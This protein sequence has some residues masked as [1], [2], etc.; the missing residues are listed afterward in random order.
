MRPKVILSVA[1]VALLI[2][3][4]ALYYRFAPA[5]APRA[6]PAVET[7]DAAG[8]APAAQPAASQRLRTVRPLEDQVPAPEQDSRASPT[9]ANHQDYVVGRVSE[10]SDLATSND[11][12]SLKVILSE[13][14]NQNAAI[15][16]A[17]L[18]ATV[19]FGGR[20]ALPALSNQMTWTEDPREKMAIQNAI[21]F[22]QL[23]SANSVKDQIMAAQQA[24]D[25]QPAN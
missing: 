21:E 16:K 18:G 7:V 4:P 3:L 17:A 24:A 10:L 5:S 25:A 23:P 13:L 2:L 19:Q 9:A 12:V 1:A 22:L 14:N 20:D 8:S 15:R 11:P 6:Q